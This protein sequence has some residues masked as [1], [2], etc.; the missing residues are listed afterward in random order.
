MTG[1]I[2]FFFFVLYITKYN[3][4]YKCLARIIWIIYNNSLIQHIER[5]WLLVRLL[6]Q[7]VRLLLVRLLVRL[8]LLN[9]PTMVKYLLIL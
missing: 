7:L 5:A 8:L 4:N 2:C 1:E 3:T 6:V 9:H